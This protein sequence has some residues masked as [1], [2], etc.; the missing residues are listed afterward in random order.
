MPGMTANWSLPYPCAGDTI[1]PS[2]FCDF[3]NAV[4]MAL[5]TV[6]ANA[7]FVANRPTA[8]IDRTVSSNTI[9]VNVPT[10]VQF[11][12]EIFDNDGMADLVV[13]NSGITVVTPGVYWASFT[14]GGIS[15][16]TTWARYRMRI[17][18]N[19]TSFIARKFI[20]DTGLSVFTD[21]NIYGALHCQAGDVIRG[22]Y[23]W[24]G[25]GGPQTM[26]R[27]SLSLSFICDL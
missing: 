2:I 11:D 4:D 15:T 6:S 19:G 7:D 8:R 14:V 16:F 3:S 17:M 20:I 13:D 23:A 18:Q 25:T 27:G 22:E 26:T 5:S 12:T 1:D 10:N 9:T 24:N 21:Q